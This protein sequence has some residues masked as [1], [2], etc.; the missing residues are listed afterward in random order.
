MVGRPPVLPPLLSL[1][2]FLCP[3]P[4]GRRRCRTSP[5]CRRCSYPPSPLFLVCR[6]PPRLGPLVRAQSSSQ[7]PS[8]AATATALCAGAGAG[9]AS[10]CVSVCP[11]SCALAQASVRPCSCSPARMQAGSLAGGPGASR[12]GMYPDFAAPGSVGSIMLPQ[13][14]PPALIWPDQVPPS[15]GTTFLASCVPLPAPTSA[16]AASA[17]GVV[18]LLL[19]RPPARGPPTARCFCTCL[20]RRPPCRPLQGHLDSAPPTPRNFV[21][22]RDQCAPHAAACTS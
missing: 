20:R 1:P 17:A 2:S 7:A 11:Y 14:P 18:R 16:A 22:I 5:P 19:L 21:P 12:T 15:L 8:P 3:L 9:G 4:T 13:G 10:M 6:V